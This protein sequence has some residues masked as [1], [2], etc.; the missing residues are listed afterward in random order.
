MSS[1]SLGAAAQPYPCDSDWP[2]VGA[3]P[4]KATAQRQAVSQ[5]R[6]TISGRV[7][8]SVHRKHAQ[9]EIPITISL[10]SNFQEPQP[11][12]FSFYDLECSIL[13]SP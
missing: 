3:D 11:N 7:V 12:S 8:V 9:L 6:V 13:G 4:L 1:F 2:A 5:S 10:G